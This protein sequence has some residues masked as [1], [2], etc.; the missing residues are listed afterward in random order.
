MKPI[1]RKLLR[2]CLFTT[3]LAPTQVFAIQE[4]NIQLLATGGI[5]PNSSSYLYAGSVMFDSVEG[6]FK[7]WGCGGVAGD[8]IIYKEAT[9]FENLQ[10]APW[11]TAMTPTAVLGTFDSWQVCDPSVVEHNGVFYL[12]YTGI[13]YDTESAHTSKMGVAVSY[14]RGR[15]FQRLFA[16]QPIKSPAYTNLYGVG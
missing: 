4:D 12:H 1:L 8:Y 16:G 3:L 6:K 13:N 5:D 15:T 14:D 2:A 11:Q 10:T 7:Y 9:V